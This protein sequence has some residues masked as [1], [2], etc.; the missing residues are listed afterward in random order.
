MALTMSA[1]SEPDQ[2]LLRQTAYR[3]TLQ[4]ILQ[5][6]AVDHRSSHGDLGQTLP[7]ADHKSLA[8]N[9]K[10]DVDA[11]SPRAST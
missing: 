8:A 5:A 3:L 1:V 10:E 7:I 6:A 4:R 2:P 9:L 11:P